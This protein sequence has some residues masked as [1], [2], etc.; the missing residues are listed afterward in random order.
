MV[1]VKAPIMKKQRVGLVLR[2]E[3]VLLGVG[4]IIAHAIFFL[5]THTLVRAYN[6]LDFGL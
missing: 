1:L 4:V 6:P 2:R 5:G 3:G